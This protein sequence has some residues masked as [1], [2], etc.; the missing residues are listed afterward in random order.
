MG[1]SNRSV[2]IGVQI[3]TSESLAGRSN[4]GEGIGVKTNNSASKGGKGCYR[5]E[6][7]PSMADLSGVGQINTRVK[8]AVLFVDAWVTVAE[9]S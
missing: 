7:T 5:G 3:N 2:E 9:L 1:R 4:C 8:C 6:R